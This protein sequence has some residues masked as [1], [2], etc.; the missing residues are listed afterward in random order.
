M[1]L[2]KQKKA[3]LVA[4]IAGDLKKY[5]VIGVASIAGLPARNYSKIK[6][7]VSDR[8]L[9]DSTRLTIMGRAIEASGRPELKELEKYFGNATVLVCTDLNAFALHKLFKQNKSKTLAKAGQITPVDIV[10]P[11]GE[12]NLPP[13]PALTDLKNAKIN[14]RIQGPKIFI[15]NDSTVAKAGEAITPAVA[16]ALGKLG[17]E[18]F[19]I[20]FLV[21]AVWENGVL[22]PGD[23][24]DI[25]DDAFRA[26]LGAAHVGAVNLCVYAEIY[27]EVSSPLIVTK[28]CREANALKRLLEVV[29]K[30]VET[31]EVKEPEAASGPEGKEG[32]VE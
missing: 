20:G 25:D 17:I 11:A 32:E 21:K 9:V 27:N 13:G 12:T 28:A 5:K 7:K 14:A 24:L 31:P 29:V 15:A 26:R 2:S 1:A 10:I 4:R 22:Y 8:V 3:E 18:P 16:G 6:K 23:V 19:E 30:G